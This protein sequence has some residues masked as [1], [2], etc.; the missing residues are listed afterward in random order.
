MSPAAW[1]AHPRMKTG[2]FFLIPSPFMQPPFFGGFPAMTTP[3][4]QWLCNACKK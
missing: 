4:R 3:A 2:E 1:V